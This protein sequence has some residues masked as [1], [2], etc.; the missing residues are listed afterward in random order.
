MVHHCFW[1]GAI[2]VCSLLGA[3]EAA[4]TVD[5]AKGLQLNGQTVPVEGTRRWPVGT[6]DELKSDE[7]PVVLTMKDGSRIVLGKQTRAKLE[8][9]TVRLL[10]GTMQYTLAAKSPLQVAVK[11][12]VLTA[13]TGLASTVSNPVAPVAPVMQLEPLAEAS[14]TLP[15]PSRRR[16]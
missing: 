10:A 4:G 9:G 14:Q 3:A 15:A 7:A 6:G 8:A 12:D 11:S 13:R 1:V 5:A 2:A 16:P